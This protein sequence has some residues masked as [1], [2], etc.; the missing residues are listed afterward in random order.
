MVRILMNGVSRMS[1]L[2]FN[3]PEKRFDCAARLEA[4]PAP[5]LWPQMITEVSYSWS[6]ARTESS[7]IHSNAVVASRAMPSSEGRPLDVQ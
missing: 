3:L 5:M 1:D 4:T 7:L 2:S 6:P